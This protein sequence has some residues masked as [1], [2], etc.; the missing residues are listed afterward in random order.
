MEMKD[1]TRIF[2][3]VYYQQANFPKKDAL[4]AKIN[5]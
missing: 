5:G 1:V 3:V 2:D 4:T